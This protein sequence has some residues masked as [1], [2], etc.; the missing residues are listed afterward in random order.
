MPAGRHL[1]RGVTGDW[2]SSSFLLWAVGFY[3]FIQFQ[4]RWA[5]EHTTWPR[6]VTVVTSRPRRP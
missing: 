6:H 3:L 2:Q 1:R 4:F 5:W